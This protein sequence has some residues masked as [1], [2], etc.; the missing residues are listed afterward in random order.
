[1]ILA[2]ARLDVNKKVR[3]MLGV[4]KLSF[5]QPEETKELTGMQIGG[6]TPVGLPESIPLWIDKAVFEAEK[7]I[8]GGGSRDKK[9]LINPK[10]LLAL[11]NSEES[12]I[13][14]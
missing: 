2:N 5:A 7:I 11:P 14:I 3:K 12:D 4:R 10:S 1:M 8:I 9:I 6:V 13:S